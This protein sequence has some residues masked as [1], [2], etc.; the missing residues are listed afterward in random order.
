MVGNSLRQIEILKIIYSHNGDVTSNV[1]VSILK[2]TRRTLISDIKA[3]NQ[4][5]E[6]IASSN[7]GYK[8]NPEFIEK[9]NSILYNFQTDEENLDSL[10]KYI[11]IKNNNVSIDEIAR[12]FYIS[13]SKL[14]KLFNQINKH[15]SSYNL[16]L[17]RKNNNV[18]I[19]GE[20]QNKRLLLSNII[21]NES[22]S[23]FSDIENFKDYFPNIPV[24]EICPM[25]VETIEEFGYSIPKY[26]EMNFLINILVT[27]SRNPFIIST[28]YEK[29]PCTS[30]KYDSRKIAY[31][32]NENLE[33]KFHIHYINKLITI[34]EIEQILEG[35]IS[36]G[37]Q[38]PKVFD[39]S[40]SFIKKIREIV[41]ETFKYYY[42][43][44]IDYQGFLSV[45]CI[46]VSEMIKRCMNS[47]SYVPTNISVKQNAPYVYEIAVGVASKI[48][49][50]F[51]VNIPEIEINLISIHIGYAVEQAIDNSSIAP[52]AIVSQFE[53]SGNL[54]AGKIVKTIGYKVQ[55]MGF[56]NSIYEIPYGLYKKC[57]II[58]TEKEE[59]KNKNICSIS[60]FASDTDII[61]IQETITSFIKDKNIQE[62]SQL[63]NKYLNENAFFVLD[64]KMD[65][66]EAIKFLCEKAYKNNDVLD[67]FEK[68]VISREKLS[69]TCFF[70]KFA[71][72]HSNIQNA[73]NTKL[74]ILI[75]KSNINWNKSK[76]RLVCLILI[77][78]ETNDD[79]RKLYAGLSE[80]LCDNTFL[81]D[82]IEKINNLDD[83]IYY[84]LQKENL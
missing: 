46:H 65:K 38:K 72:P 42:L 32:I 48:S 37:D 22:Y 51:N 60:P 40:D 21:H 35:F 30:Q 34:K 41:E 81:F 2:I 27:L 12:N 77:K 74:Y 79:F 59:F 58:S 17:N 24:D 67:G 14:T 73:I 20:E 50:T 75:N 84:L 64:K 54:I 76:I 43:T 26:Y 55:I 62:V 1:I 29:P 28:S 57:L 16:S 3:I 45:F 71:I 44:S 8:I 10:I 66:N 11:L 13:S 36:R 33:N 9:V 53:K 61:K 83:F 15:L 70:D 63:I 78:R 39:L 68:Q 80:I 69:S 31:R 52:I 23:F 82:N 47:I 56:Y 19:D 49:K 5:D 4:T 7:K 6:I 18:S 25:V